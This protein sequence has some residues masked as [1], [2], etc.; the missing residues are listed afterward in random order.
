MKAYGKVLAE[1]FKTPP[2]S[3]Q[4]LEMHHVEKSEL[5]KDEPKKP[6]LDLEL[7][8]NDMIVA[9]ISSKLE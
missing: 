5:A 8:F 6:E 4:I 3:N 1:A 9:T 2:L 7:C